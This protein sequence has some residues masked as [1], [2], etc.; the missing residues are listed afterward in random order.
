[1]NAGTL[2]P[3]SGAIEIEM[4]EETDWA[5]DLNPSGMK[6]VGELAMVGTG[7]AIA[8]AVFHAAGRRVRHLPITIEDVV[9][10]VTQH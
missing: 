5:P 3:A 9:R 6:G 1:L 2:I 4:L 8:N 10:A 7:A